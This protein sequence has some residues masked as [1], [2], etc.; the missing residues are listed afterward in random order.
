MIDYAHVRLE[1]PATALIRFRTGES[2]RT[3]EVVPGAVFADYDGEG[4]LLSIE[5]LGGGTGVRAAGV[6]WELPPEGRPP[7]KP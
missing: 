6:P 7:K 1:G 2:A 5:L 4:R 3:V